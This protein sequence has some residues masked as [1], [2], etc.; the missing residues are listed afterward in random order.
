MR[1]HTSEHGFTLLELLA[2]TAI[3]LVVIGTA[4]TAFKDGVG[5]TK[6][7]SDIAETTQNLRSGTNM[8]IHDLVLAGRGVPTGG[9]SIPSGAGALQ[10]LRPSPPGLGYTFDNVGATTLTAIT[11]GSNKGPAVD[12]QTTDMVTILSLDP[13][14]DTCLLAPLSVKAWNDP[15]G[16]ALPHMNDQNGTGFNVVNINNAKCPD[17][18]GGFNGDWLNGSPTQAPIVKGD[19]LMFTDANG[20]TA[21]QTVTS[22]DPTNVYFAQNANDQFGFNQPGA[23]AGSIKKLVGALDVKRVIMYTYYVDPPAIANQFTPRLMRRY[24][25]GSA[26][27]LAGVVEDL[28]FSYDLVDSATNTAPTGVLDLPVVLN[29]NN[30]SA[31]MI[32]KVTVHVGVRSEVKSL[33]LG[34]YLRSHI[35]TV[36]SIRN[37][38]FVDRYK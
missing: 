35:S 19:L 22:T 3:S 14:L 32:K 21:I 13:I 30:Y 1:I 11:S 2:S 29:G 6:S 4:M 23:A 17:G 28:Q 16:A 24:N 37:L 26:Q 20:A 33:K 27:A 10:I 5:M 31:N 18:M 38:A 25:M 8:L 7:A 9:I 15:A 34:D 36:V 12:G